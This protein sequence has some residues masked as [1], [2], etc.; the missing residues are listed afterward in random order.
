MRSPARAARSN[1][2]PLVALVAT[3]VVLTV[4]LLGFLGTEATPSFRA[5]ACGLPSGWLE[6]VKRGYFEP[7][8]GQISLL[9]RFPGYM[10]S[11]AGGWSHS[12]PW[13]HLQRVPLVFYGP[14]VVPDSGEVAR[15]VTVADVAPTL[16]TLMRGFYRTEG[17]S[18]DEVARISGKLLERSPP[19]LIVTIVWD[20]GGWNTLDQW[21]EDWPNLRR[22][23]EEGTSYVN[24]T[25]GS[26]PSVTPAV[27]TT[28]GT[29]FFPETHGIV[30]VPMRDERGEVVDAFL[31][32]ESSRFIQI[33]T[34]VERWDE[35][36][37]NRARIAMI[38]YEPWHL[39][40]IGKG[41]EKPGGDKDDAVWLDIETNEWITN[42]DHYRL[43]PA[44]ARTSGLDRDVEELDARDGDVDGAWR[45]HEILD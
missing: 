26:S 45:G 13:P 32:G 44:I 15:P 6:R 41:A 20:G 43:P 33:P 3:A 7:R 8:S 14:G 5:Q 29:G 24:A 18:L 28:L 25:V 34:L 30:D 23:M 4:A 36:Q 39:G 42:P 16:M 21:P 12:G 11:G 1:R 40:M 22:L 37:G 27:H 17:D 10:A 19:K 38:G 2:V 9:P 35:Q 31:K